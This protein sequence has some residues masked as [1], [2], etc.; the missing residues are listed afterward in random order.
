MLNRILT[1]VLERVL[2]NF[3]SQ[4]YFLK[5]YE[6]QTNLYP[7]ANSYLEMLRNE[8]FL[9]LKVQ[10][11]IDIFPKE[12]ENLLKDPKNLTSNYFTEK[13]ENRR[14]AN[15]NYEDISEFIQNEKK[16]LKREK[17]RSLIESL[18]GTYNSQSQED[19]KKKNLKQYYKLYIAE[20]ETHLE[21]LWNKNINLE[22]KLKNEKKFENESE[23]V[24]FKLMGIK[25]NKFKKIHD[26]FKAEGDGEIEGC[27]NPH[28]V[29]NS[30]SLVEIS[31]K[32]DK[33]LIENLKLKRENLELKN[34]KKI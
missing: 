23:S 31:D 30:V 34:I 18:Y 22:Q 14:L 27:S 11:T 26:I 24:I 17:K 6:G 12:H 13:K 21:E 25:Y 10:E 2:C 28:C 7:T 16:N 1:I 8:S 3:S 5:M 29:S 32:Y 33:L 15:N 19:T 9:K 4:F 20:L